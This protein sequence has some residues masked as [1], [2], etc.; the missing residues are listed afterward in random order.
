MI[1]YFLNENSIDIIVESVL[2][3]KYDPKFVWGYVEV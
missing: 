2:D 1:I 3:L